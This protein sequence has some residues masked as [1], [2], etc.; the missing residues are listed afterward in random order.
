MIKSINAPAGIDLAPHTE[1]REY[2][3]HL[4]RLNWLFKT[5]Q[6]TRPADGSLVKI[7]DVGCGTGNITVPLGLVPNSEVVGIDMH[8][9]NIDLTRTKITTPNV[10]VEFSML[11]DFDI[12]GFDYII[13]TEVLEH[14]P[15]YG[16]LLEDISRRAKPT[17]QLLVTIPNGWGPFEI[18]VTP[19]YWLRRMGLN[20]FIRKVKNLV[21]KKEPY[22][23]NQEED[24]H[25]NF[26]TQAKLRR[27]C[28]QYRFNLVEFTKAFVFS[29]VFET[30]L[31]F[32]SLNKIAYYDNRLAQKL[33]RAFASGWYLRFTKK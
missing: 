13:F 16:A 2:P 25:V 12:S 1:Y 24:P 4:E 33:P 26:F 14:I 20:G 27:D 10:R 5:I 19:M 6:E 15:G 21:G 8:Q 22:A 29:P 23:L 31:P 28:E 3:V 9:P 11:Q 7:L 32:I 30:Y 17:M 18:A